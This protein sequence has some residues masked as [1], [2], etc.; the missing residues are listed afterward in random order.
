MT[1]SEWATQKAEF[2]RKIRKTAILSPEET[3]LRQQYQALLSKEAELEPEAAESPEA[4]ASRN[5]Q[6]GR[7]YI[8]NARDIY[9]GEVHIHQNGAFGKDPEILQETYLRRLFHRT[10]QIYLSGIDRKAAKDEADAYLSLS[11]IYIALLA[12]DGQSSAVEQINRHSRIVILGDPGSG[13]STFVNFVAMCLAGELLGNEIANLKLL[14]TSAPQ[15]QHG[16]LLPVLVTLR[17][18]AAKSLPPKGETASAEHLWNFIAGELQSASLKE[19]SPILRQILLKQGGLILLDGLD[20]VPEADLRRNQLKQVVEDFLLTFSRCR[21]VVTSRIYAYQEQ[22]WKLIYLDEI[23]DEENSEKTNLI[24]RAFKTSVLTP[25]TQYQ[26]HQFIEHWYKHFAEKR[27]MER[28]DALGKAKILKQAI[29]QNKRLSELA[30]RPL[31]LTLM[32]SLHAWRGG[33]LPEKREELYDDAVDLLLDWWESPKV[34]RDAAGNLII[35]QKSL[36]ELLNVGKER[37]RSVLNTLAFQAHHNQAELAGTADITEEHLI[38]TLMRFSQ[39]RNLRPALLVDYLSERAGLLVPRGVGIY[40]FPHRTFQEYLAACYLTDDNYP[41]KVAELAIQEPNRWREALLLA[42]AKAARGTASAIWQLA[43]TLCWQEV[44]QVDATPGMVW[45]ALLAGQALAETIEL[46]QIEDYNRPKLRRINRWL[47]AILT[48]RIPSERPLLNLANTI[49]AKFDIRPGIGVD[50]YGLPD[51]AW[52][53]VPEGDFIMGEG[54]NEHTVY[55]SAFQISR[56]PVTNTQYQ[57]FIDDGGYDEHWK[58]CWSK[59]GWNWLKQNNITAPEKYENPFDLPNH[60]VVGV[61]WYEASAFCQ[62]LTQRQRDKD[63]L[64][65]DQ[66]IRLATEAEWEKSARGTDGRLYPWGNEKIMP[67]SANYI[68]SDLDA[69]SAVGR[70]PSGTSLYGCEDMTGNVWEWCQNLYN[71]WGMW[72]VMRGGAWNVDAGRCRCSYRNDGHPGIHDYVVGF[73]L[74]KAPLEKE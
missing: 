8:E 40:T 48:K 2:E 43:E 39:N 53:E 38:G 20:E 71:S 66:E 63:K 28:N 50:K 59:E 29:F 56:Y 25:F 11:A 34:I 9:S 54:A 35:A 1:R 27:G 10:S 70:F 13:K 32:A 57:P 37:V 15:W 14:N 68:Y 45:G 55:V 67:E 30:E 21:I 62:W 24:E 73:R 65:K 22:N 69:T 49:L 33:S 47:M 18:F 60:P 74:V 52:C 16:P 44:K 42:G 26:I 3:E 58:F 61:S 36:S 17:E 64:S 41:K 51:I 6:A 46:D 72:R 23:S 4:E 5:I 31:L 7:D 19:Y 12:D